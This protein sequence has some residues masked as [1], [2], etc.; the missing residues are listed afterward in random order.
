M[1]NIES[2]EGLETD[3]GLDEDA[4]DLIFFK[5]FA[6]VLMLK[7]FLIKVSIIGVFHY[8]A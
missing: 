2:V 6:C 7:N 8:N 1:Q 4:P 3:D 5:K